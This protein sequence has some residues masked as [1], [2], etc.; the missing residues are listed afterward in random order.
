MEDILR[1]GK[2]K[3]AYYFE[4]QIGQGINRVVR[5]TSLESGEEVAIKIIDLSEV[6]SEAD[7]EYLYR[8]IE[9]LSEVDHPSVVQLKECYEEKKDDSHFF[10]MIFELMKGG[11]LAEAIME[12]E[13]LSEE[14]A[15]SVL[16]PMV[17]AVA[18]LH[19][20]GIVHR[21]LKVTIRILTN[22]A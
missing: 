4:N 3:E 2:V 1:E 13:F 17:D 6:E 19:D 22:S 21:D 15:A 20:F 14:N 16:R 5:G 7:L 8:E 12:E 18:Y 11:T 9:L 10:Y